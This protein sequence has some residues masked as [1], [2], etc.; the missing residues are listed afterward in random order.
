MPTLLM[1]FD[2]PMQSWG[3]RSQFAS[4]DT[5]TEPTKSGVVG[6]LAAALGLPQDADEDIQHLATLRMGVRVDREG[7]VES[8]FHTVQNVPNTE[9]KNHR[10]A[11]TK[12]FYLADAL[13]LVALES[14]DTRLLH[15]LE[16]ALHQPRWPLYLGRKAFVPAR[17]IP[18]RGLPGEHRSITQRP[19]DDALSL[20]P[21]LENQPRIRAR[22]RATPTPPPPMWLRTIVDADPLAL[23]VELRHDQPLSFRP[24]HRAYAPRAVQISHIPLPPELIDYHTV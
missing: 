17:P 20:H 3:I 1:C 24:Q 16:D 14:D 2:A 15:K 22:Q 7:V 13:F 8:D 9:G 4:R 23:D 6:L 12:R 18:I 19:L 5:A 11:V 10:T 21:W